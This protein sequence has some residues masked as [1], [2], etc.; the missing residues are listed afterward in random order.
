MTQHK[1]DTCIACGQSG[2]NSSQCP[3]TRWPRSLLTWVLAAIG[4][5]TLSWLPL[6][7]MTP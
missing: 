7:M 6:W 5:I 2:H 3:G 1:T 4:C